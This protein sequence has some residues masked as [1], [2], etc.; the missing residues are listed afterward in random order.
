M[1]TTQRQISKIDNQQK[2]NGNDNKREDNIEPDNFSKNE[3]DENNSSLYEKFYS[4][5]KEAKNQELN[6][7]YENSNK[8]TNLSD[9][10]KKIKNNNNAKNIIKTTLDY[11]AE[12]NMFI[13]KKKE[14]INVTQDNIC[15]QKKTKLDEESNNKKIF[16]NNVHKNVNKNVNKNIKQIFKIQKINENKN[17]YYH[18]KNNVMND[19][20]HNSPNIELNEE[21]MDEINK[22]YPEEEENEE[23]NLY[24][25]IDAFSDELINQE[26][27][28]DEFISEKNEPILCQIKSNEIQYENTIIIEPYRQHMTDMRV[29]NI[30]NT[31]DSS[32]NSITHNYNNYL[33]S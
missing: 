23:N 18:T 30:H 19:E 20:F 24:N 9:N 2:E 25:R 7:Q 31:S 22:S 28:E 4:N 27:N 1:T 17:K 29:I 8:S 11:D 32:T 6:N 3:G 26:I 16:K 14:Y 21:L 33:N 15:L 12:N 5:N 13:E 10:N